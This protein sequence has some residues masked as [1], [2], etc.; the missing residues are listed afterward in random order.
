[1]KKRKDEISFLA[2]LILFF[3]RIKKKISSLR[4]FG[5]INER[6]KALSGYSGR[7]GSEESRLSYGFGIAKVTAAFLLAVLLIVTLLFG[8]GVV[9]YEKIYYMLKDI[10]YIKSFDEGM[11]DSLSYSEPV[12]NQ[13]FADFKNGL[14]VASDSELKLFT[15]TGRVTLTEGSEFT[16]PRVSVSSGYAL[17]YD[18]GRKAFSIYNSFVKLYSERTDYPIALADM[19]ENG[20]FLIVTSSS[21]YSSVVKIYSN[22]FSMICE[23]SKNDRVISASLSENGRFAAITSLSAQD[24]ESRVSVSILDTKKN[25]V[26]SEL[27]LSGDMPYMCEF[28]SNERIVLILDSRVCVINRR[29]DII[30]EFAYPS[31]LERI[32]IQGDGFALLFSENGGGKKSLDVFDKDCVIVFSKQVG[33]SVKDMRLSDGAVYIL[34]SREVVRISTSLGTEAVKETHLDNARLLVLGD[35]RLLVCSQ[36]AGSYISFD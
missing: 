26:V 33:G 4:I 31:S 23:Y 16:N 3:R 19:A 9:S 17:I 12:Q 32:D 34:K 6:Q 10:S 15:S 29:G 30:G 1:M 5:R 14:L 36:T 25:E 20:Q 22:D 7:D 35:G 21:K 13:V 11:P 27:L 8:S 2:K 18:Q 28:L 24:G